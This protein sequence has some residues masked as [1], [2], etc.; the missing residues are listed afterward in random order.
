MTSIFVAASRFPD[1]VSRSRGACPSFAGSLPPSDI[2]GRRECRALAAPAASRAKI[3]K[4]DEHSHHGHIGFTQHSPRNGFNGFLR[5]L[6]GD[7]LVVTVACELWFC[8]P[9]WTSKNL[10]QLD[11]SAGASGPHDFAVREH[12]PF[13]DTR[14]DR[15]RGSTRPAITLRAQRCCVHRIPPR[16]PDDREPPLCGT[17]RDD[18]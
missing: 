16:V 9:G 7:R 17:R 14:V 5:D 18:F 6:L 10:R 11:A 3:K 4:H 13:V 1:T 8:Q 2:R 12:A 15:S